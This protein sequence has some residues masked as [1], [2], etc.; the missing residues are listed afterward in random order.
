MYIVFTYTTSQRR[1]EVRNKMK[2]YIVIRLIFLML[3]ITGVLLSVGAY[4]MLHTTYKRF[5]SEASN[6]ISQI[7]SI[8]IENDETA[9]QL[10]EELKIDFLIRANAAAYMIQYNQ[11]IIYDL[12]MLNH[13]TELL[14]IDEIHLFTPEGKIYSGNVPEYYGYTF[15]SGSQMQFFMPL[16]DDYDLELAQDVTPNTAEEKEM[17]YVAVWS[18]DRQHI[19]QIGIEPLRLLKAMAETELSYIFSR[20]TP[21]THTVFFAVDAETEEI[22]SSTDQASNHSNLEELGLSNFQDSD[23]GLTQ[24]ATIGDEP[25]HVLLLEQ[26]DGIYIGYF[27]SFSSLYEPTLISISYLIA[28]SLAVALIVIILIYF[29]LDRVVLHGLLDLEKGMK[30]IAGGN[31]E[32]KIN[33]SGVPEL[34]SLSENVDFMVRRVIETSRKFSTIFEY[35][36]IPIAMYECNSNTVT[37]TGMLAEILQISNEQLEQKLISSTVFL[38]YIEEIMSYPHASEKNLYVFTTGG[39]ERFLKIM[40]YQDGTSDWGIIID[41]TDEIVEK[42]TI[43]KERDVDFLTGLYGKR[44]FFEQLKELSL[45]PNVV[46]KAAILM[47]DLDNLKYVNDTWGH[48][49]GDTFIHTAAN[50]LHD[51]EHEN[52]L[53]ARL[54]GDE[55]AMIL[56][57]E[58]DYQELELKLQKLEKHLENKHIKTP[59]GT[60]HRVS[61]SVGYALYPK[62]NKSIMTCLNFA[63]KAMYKAKSRCKGSM[64]KYTSD[65]QNEDGYTDE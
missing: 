16:L 42:I 1:S 29:L 58:D 30:L 5:H 35:V 21:S 59:T 19:V 62:Q 25:G 10:Q 44:Y 3:V 31:L 41:S 28:I 40:R 54:S 50:L 46:K 56:Y 52:K 2:K 23:I 27:Q 38:S 51:F 45:H 57:G 39:G 12:D 18:Q 26:K 8:L 53:C 17:Q 20:L 6:Q 61:A 47:F 49:T 65:N 22:V 13:I 37:T 55:L 33:V 60:E 24:N 7:E 4:S 43:K 64:E 32:Y 48:E 36:K 9:M 14:Q 34:E 15:D 63:D 11:D